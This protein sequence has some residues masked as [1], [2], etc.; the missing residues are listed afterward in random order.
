MVCVI[1][2][3]SSFYKSICLQKIIKLYLLNFLA[4]SHPVLMADFF[5]VEAWRLLCGGGTG[6]SFSFVSSIFLSSRLVNSMT[7]HEIH[8]RNS[9][10]RNVPVA[11]LY[12]HF[13]FENVGS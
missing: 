11:A 9:K 6:G 13:C 2:Q 4:D 5:S 1:G 3:K 12:L 7:Q 10:V 8:D